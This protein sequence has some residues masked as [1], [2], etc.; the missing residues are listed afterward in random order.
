MLKI[1][2]SYLF[3]IFAAIVCGLVIALYIVLALFAILLYL[4]ASI[5]LFFGDL[6]AQALDATPNGQKV[7]G[8]LCK[9]PLK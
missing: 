6:L 1:S 5:I 8:W 9:T 4:A 2:D 7:K 3:N